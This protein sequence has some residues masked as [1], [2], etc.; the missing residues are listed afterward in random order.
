[1][2]L[3]LFEKRIEGDDALLELARL[4][5]QQA[6]MGAEMHAATPQQLEELMRFRPSFVKSTTEGGPAG[7]LPVIVHLPRHFNLLNEDHRNQIT[8]M[9]SAF[10]GRIYGQ[11]I[12]DHSDLISRA[13]D[14][15]KAA[16]AIESRLTDIRACPLLFVEY[17]AG[18]EPRMFARFFESI[19][20]LNHISSC[21][22]IG[23]VGIKQ[24]RNTFASMHPGEDICALKSLPG[25][26]PEMIS[27][28]ETAVGSGL[29][30]V[31]DLIEALGKIGKPV[32]FHLHDGHPLS[33]FSPYGVSDHLSFLMEMPLGFEYRGRRS[34]PLMFGRAGLQQIA[35]KAVQSIGRER[36]SFTLEIHPLAGQLALGDA[37]PLFNQWVDK[38]HAER[39]NHWLVVLSENHNALLEGLNVK[40]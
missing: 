35:K 3:G 39:V 25:R 40:A 30:T 27:D 34:V 10:A 29:P 32:H 2:T 23:H 11:V 7:D 31:L 19:R 9:A 22:D 13:D 8:A 17:A 38:T 36:V 15:V 33:T 6:G 14:F 21:I 16:R 28:V 37:A 20:E 26:I 12:H 24:A 4:R 18:L 1:M 5:F